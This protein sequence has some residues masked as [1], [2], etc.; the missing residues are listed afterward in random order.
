MGC[1]VLNGL[2]FYWKVIDEQTY[3]KPAAIMGTKKILHV[4]QPKK[5]WN[6][7]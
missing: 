6:H 3:E 4:A 1:T 7:M 5:K 2:V